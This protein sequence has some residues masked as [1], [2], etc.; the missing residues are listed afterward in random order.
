MRNLARTITDWTYTKRGARS[1]LGPVYKFLMAFRQFLVK[2]LPSALSQSPQACQ[3]SPR[4]IEWLAEEYL[5]S[6]TALGFSHFNLKSEF[7]KGEARFRQR[8]RRHLIEIH[9]EISSEVDI[10]ILVSLAV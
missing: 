2:Y 7:D 10:D 8:L 1:E 4:E 9:S 6:L 5:K 3:T